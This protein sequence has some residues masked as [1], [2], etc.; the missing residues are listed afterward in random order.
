[1]AIGRVQRITNTTPSAAVSS[2]TN[3]SK[4]LQNQLQIKQQNLKKL[5]TDS[6]M[7]IDEKEKE[8]QELQK[9]I[10]ELKRKLEQMRLK[11]EEQEKTEK[12]EQKKE[13]NLEEAAKTESEKAENE[14]NSVKA[15]EEEKLERK[16]L[17][18]SEVQ[19]MLDSNIALKEDMVQ[20][21]V[22]YDLENNMRVLSSEI[23][24]DE[25]REVDTSSKKE[26]KKELRDRENFWVEMQ[27][28]KLEDTI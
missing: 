15:T 2:I 7:S 5:S 20:Q 26:D 25:R 9:E 4:S 21:G 10:E 11:Q 1:M 28:P 13:I 23:K 16:E 12:S 3:T 24:Q 17:S 14:T 27:K 6:H 22:Q 8:R 18:A 19:Q